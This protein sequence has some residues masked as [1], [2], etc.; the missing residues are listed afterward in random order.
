MSPRRRGFT[1][2]ELLVVIRIIAALIAMLLPVLNGAR[3]HGERAQC[4]SN[5]R[6]LAIAFISSCRRSGGGLPDSQPDAEHGKR[7]GRRPGDQ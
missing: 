6:Q 7:A 5:L 1:L 4:A 2:A 3:R